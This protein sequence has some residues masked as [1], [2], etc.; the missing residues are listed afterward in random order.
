MLLILNPCGWSIRNV[1]HMQHDVS[2]HQCDFYICQ[3]VCIENTEAFTSSLIII[4]V[5]EC[6]D[7]DDV[8]L[9]RFVR[10]KCALNDSCLPP[11]IP[12]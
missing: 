8:T 2:L 10:L 7:Y 11:K 4:F 3:S 6:T 9:A 12:H 1:L 5:Q